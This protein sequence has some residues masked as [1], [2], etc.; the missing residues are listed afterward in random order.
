[1]EKFVIA[2]SREF[3]AGGRHVGEKLGLELGIP[4]YSR[5]I[6]EQAAERSGLSVNFLEQLEERASNS[7]PTVMSV[8][9][10]AADSK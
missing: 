4:F 8:G 2:I 9:I 10:I 6:I 1:M 3:G 7:F 5:D